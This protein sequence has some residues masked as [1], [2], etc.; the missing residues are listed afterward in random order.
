MW[1][2]SLTLLCFLAGCLNATEVDCCL[3]YF[4]VI[5]SKYNIDALYLFPYGMLTLSCFCIF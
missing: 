5:V 2:W 3:F 4:C 1:K